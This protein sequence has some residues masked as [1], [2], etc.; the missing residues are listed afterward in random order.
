[1]LARF[2]VTCYCINFDGTHFFVNGIQNEAQYAESFRFLVTV[3]GDLD[4]DRE[5]YDA[6]QRYILSNAE[7]GTDGLVIY[8]DLIAEPCYS[9]VSEIRLCISESQPPI[10]TYSGADAEAIL[11]LLEN[12]SYFPCEPE[13]YVYCMKLTMV[14]GEGTEIVVELEMNSGICRYGTQIY[15]Y[16]SLP[17]MFLSLGIEQWPDAVLEEFGF[18]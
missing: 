13:E 4:D 14:N 16:G 10:K 15:E 1:M 9:G 11:S 8:E 18:N 2:F 6:Y 12:A 17:D 3:S 5:P 7:D